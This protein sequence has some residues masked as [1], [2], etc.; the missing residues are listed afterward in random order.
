KDNLQ[1]AFDIEIIADEAAGIHHAGLIVRRKQN[2]FEFDL[3]LS[4]NGLNSKEIFLPESADEQTDEFIFLFGDEKIIR[5]VNVKPVRRWEIF[6]VLHSHTDLGFTAPVSE[7]A[8]IHN[9]N[10]DLAILYCKETEHWPEESRFKWTCEV[11]WQIQNYLAQRSS[12]KIED[13]IQLV[14]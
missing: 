10:T 13:L 12:A 14:K 5:K 1:Q 8:Q 6:L 11:S 2:Q 7:V 3:G 9:D 4:R